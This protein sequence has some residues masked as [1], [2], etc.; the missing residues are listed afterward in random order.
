MQGVCEGWTKCDIRF[1]RTN[2]FFARMRQLRLLVDKDEK[3]ECI[4]N[5][6]FP[7]ATKNNCF[8]SNLK[9]KV[10]KG[11]VYVANSFS[12]ETCGTMR[13]GQH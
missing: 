3:W 6:L 11:L 2:I 1:R 9:S 4:P 7:T 12:L 10:F 5:E 13:T 8:S